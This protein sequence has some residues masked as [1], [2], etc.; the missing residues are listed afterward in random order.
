VIQA[1][2]LSQA[3]RRLASWPARNILDPVR[4]LAHMG[5]RA[6]LPPHQPPVLLLVPV[7]VCV[8]TVRSARERGAEHAAPP[9]HQATQ[10]PPT[11]HPPTPARRA[12]C[13]AQTAAWGGG[14]GSCRHGTHGRVTHTTCYSLFHP[15]AQMSSPPHHHHH[16]PATHL[17]RTWW[18]PCALAGWARVRLGVCWGVWG[19]H[20]NF[21]G[22][23]RITPPTTTAAPF[24][25]FLLPS[26][27]LL[28]YLRG[29]WFA[30]AGP[31]CL[32]PRAA[33]A[34]HPQLD[35][36]PRAAEAPPAVDLPQLPGQEQVTRRA[37]PAPPP[38]TAACRRL[39]RRQ[40]C[41]QR[42]S[43]TTVTAACRRL[44]RRRPRAPRPPA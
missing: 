14:E 21:I 36:G 24:P 8:H 42:I 22:P 35:P 9:T 33:G 26:Q 39:R 2:T 1:R 12:E 19:R 29:H 34:R 41:L 28:P 44:R 17:M 32:P 11:A 10:H 4:L 3:N 43:T 38:V 31:V 7:P 5:V 13:G 23:A 20:L 40:L 27:A 37:D 25:S 16:T 18:R 15:S 30:V 6:C